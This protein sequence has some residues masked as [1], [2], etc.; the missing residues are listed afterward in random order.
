M[1]PE[2]KKA[3]QKRTQEISLESEKLK[4]LLM[5]AVEQFEQAKKKVANLTEQLGRLSHE[6]Q[7][8]EE[9]ANIG[10]QNA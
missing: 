6:K 1:N 4:K 7:K 5:D 8:I 3:L 10:R 2:T 9:D